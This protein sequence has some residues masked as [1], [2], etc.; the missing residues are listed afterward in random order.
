M[1]APTESLEQQ[2]GLKPIER[3]VLNN[4]FWSFHHSQGNPVQQTLTSIHLARQ[5]DKDEI[6]PINAFKERL[7][8]HIERI[9]VPH[10]HIREGIDEQTGQKKVYSDK[11]FQEN[12]S[13]F[14]SQWYRLMTIFDRVFYDLQDPRDMNWFGGFDGNV[15]EANKLPEKVLLYQVAS[16]MI[17]ADLT[18]QEKERPNRDTDSDPHSSH[19]QMYAFNNVPAQ[20]PEYAKLYK[21]IKKALAQQGVIADASIAEDKISEADGVSLK[22]KFNK[23]VHE[24]EKNHQGKKIIPESA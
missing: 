4:F 19:L 9:K 23:L 10:N 24:W 12:E 20:S 22:G 16:H 14:Q 15:Y 21:D 18:Y 5:Y 7:L 17:D 1:D 11:E 2:N 6:G 8:A 13:G 3:K